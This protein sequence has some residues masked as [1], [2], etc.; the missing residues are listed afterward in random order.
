MK[1]QHVHTAGLGKIAWS[2]RLRLPIVSLGLLG[3]LIPAGGCGRSS[4][5]T[6]WQHE[7]QA[8]DGRP[9]VASNA[10]PG[11]ASDN[12]FRHDAGRVLAG[13]TLSHAFSFKNTAAGP[14]RI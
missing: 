11:Q 6:D 10:E 7:M 14:I 5:G 2:R 8:P 12:D 9:S 3:I 13:T 4:A 1:T